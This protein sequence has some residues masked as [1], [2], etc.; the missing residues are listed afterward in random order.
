[1]KTQIHINP[2]TDNYLDRG[3]QKVLLPFRCFQ[4]VV[5]LSCFSIEYNC[6]RP[7]RACYYVVS[8]MAILG[9]IAVHM[10]NLFWNEYDDKVI[11][12]MI[13]FIRSHVFFSVLPFIFFYVL[14]IIQ[15]RD[16][17]RLILKIQKAFR[18]IHFKQYKKVA[19][20][21]WFAL[22][23]YSLSYIACVAAARDLSMIVY[24]FTLLFFDALI[25]YGGSII[26]LIRDGIF[27]WMD[28][29]EYYSK[30]CLALEEENYDDKSKKLFQAYVNLLEAF[31]I[32]KEIFQ[33]V[34]RS[35]LCG[36]CFCMLRQKQILFSK[37]TKT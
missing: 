10:Y 17:L 33:F 21:N 32:F 6:I 37:L 26:R 5:F 25:T 4:H 18:L 2:I 29:V 13:F 7:H 30:I 1:M 27:S 20:R 15:R 24:L 36:V 3:F 31:D 34:V 12:Y 19:K 11:P 14:N 8:L 22:L 28:E 23:R 35:D 9:F 16:H